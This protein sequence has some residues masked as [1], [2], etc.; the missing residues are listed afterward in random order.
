MDLK[1]NN[2]LI[3]MD[4]SQDSPSPIGIWVLTDFGISAFKADDDSDTAKFVSVRDYFQNLTINT[5]PHRNPGSYQPPEVERE[6]HLSSGRGNTAKEGSAGRRGDIWSFGCIFSEVLAFS[7]GQADL[8]QEFRN[9]RKAHR[10][11]YFYEIDSDRDTL[12]LPGAGPQ[13]RVRPSIV[14]WLGELPGRFTFPKRAIDCTVETIQRILIPD[15]SMRPKAHELLRMLNHVKNHVLEAKNPGGYPSNCPLEHPFSPPLQALPSPPPLPTPRPSIPAETVTGFGVRGP[16]ESGFIPSISRTDTINQEVLF[17]RFGGFQS[18]SDGASEPSGDRAN[19]PNRNSVPTSL[20][21]ESPL[22][23]GISNSPER[24]T[25]S[26]S[27]T[28]PTRTTGSGV[29]EPRT[30]LHALMN[31]P[32]KPR[33]IDGTMQAL[34]PG[35]SKLETISFHLCSTGDRLAY[36]VKTT[37]SQHTVYLYKLRSSDRKVER[38]RSLDLPQGKDIQWKRVACA[39]N[40]VVVWGSCSGAK[41][42]SRITVSAPELA[43]RC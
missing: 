19:S 10:N 13:Y 4:P 39:G 37:K 14:R 15:G 41:Q 33:R 22:G 28:L 18:G 36:L 26:F 30:A 12:M 7:L 31:D 20:Q 32:N 40:Y 17:S 16:G 34:A 35:L 9:A 29:R 1:P 38:I 8:V 21:A 27:D 25:P 5:V 11:D 23:L 3:D 6:N 42:V 2:I 43:N 24:G